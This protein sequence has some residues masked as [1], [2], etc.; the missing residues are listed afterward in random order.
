MD[1]TQ[2]FG[3]H[4]VVIPHETK[5]ADKNVNG[6]WTVKGSIRVNLEG[7]SIA[8]VIEAAKSTWRIKRQTCRARMS[9]EN[10]TKHLNT[11]VSW[12]DVGKQAQD[13]N[14]AFAAQFAA[15]SPEERKAKLRMLEE[16]DKAGFGP[17]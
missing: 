2:K 10:A 5:S 8:D 4:V 3:K 9:R 15:S 16:L 6:P 7:A 11:E 13:V 1:L 17:R 12:R 14:D